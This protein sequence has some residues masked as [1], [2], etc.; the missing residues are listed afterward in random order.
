[1]SL[2]RVEGGAGCEGDDACW[3]WAADRAQGVKCKPLTYKHLQDMRAANGE[4]A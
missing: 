4:H 3:L 2:C 1:M